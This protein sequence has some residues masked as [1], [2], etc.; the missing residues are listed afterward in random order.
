M[1][2]ELQEI[3]LGLSKELKEG[4]KDPEFL[5]DETC[6]TPSLKYYVCLRHRLAKY[7]IQVNA[8]GPFTRKE[9][10]DQ[11]QLDHKKMKNDF[12]HDPSFRRFLEEVRSHFSE[13]E[14]NFVNECKFDRLLR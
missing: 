6:F 4:L 1:A 9:A 11:V 8:Y 7:R 3:E 5:K 12:P 13:M 10:K 2:N 14:W